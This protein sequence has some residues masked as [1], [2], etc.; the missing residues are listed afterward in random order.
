MLIESLT[1]GQ[2]LFAAAVL[3]AAYLVRGITSFGSALVA[4]PPLAMILPLTIVVPMIVLLD[5]LG[6]LTH[7]VRNLH[8]IRWHDL[9]PLLPFTLIGILT[10]L[11]LLKSLNPEL[12]QT[13]LAIFIISYAIYTLLPLPELKGSRLWAVPAGLMAGLIGTL[14]GTGGPFTV[15]YLQLRQLDKT[16]FRGTIA[17]IFLLDGGTRL[18]GF[19]L[20]G[21]YS[22]DTLILIT[23]ALPIMAG[24]LYVGGHIHTNL[25]QQAF[26]RIISAILL[27][28]GFSLL[29][30]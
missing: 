1:T 22:I 19:T 6:S 29:L 4:V 26:V 25:S 16:A 30:K 8:H 17:T 27:I 20:S 7:S 13:A 14:F 5:N 21:F 3:F 12:L 2:L 10:A 18:I 23:A 11:Y 28:S 24:G 9:W 15:I